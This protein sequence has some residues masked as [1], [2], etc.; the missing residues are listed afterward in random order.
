[1]CTVFT[2]QLLLIQGERVDLPSFLRIQYRVVWLMIE[3]WVFFHFFL[4]TKV[5]G[6]WGA[7]WGMYWCY[8][9]YSLD[10]KG[11][12]GHWC[13]F[14]RTAGDEL[15]V[16]LGGARSSGAPLSLSLLSPAMTVPVF[17]RPPFWWH[18]SHM[19]HASLER[20]R[21]FHAPPAVCVLLLQLR[22][23]TYSQHQGVSC[24]RKMTLGG[25]KKKGLYLTR[26]LKVRGV[27]FNVKILQVSHLKVDLF[28]FSPQTA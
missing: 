20:N 14:R 13:L 27:F 11:L 24:L 18:R 15:R 16:Y 28:L 12:L 3:Y 4:S 6:K 19:L 17:M 2:F 1:M 10:V 9:C 22:F 23:T 21:C 8:V 25:H 26:K 7:W 5:L